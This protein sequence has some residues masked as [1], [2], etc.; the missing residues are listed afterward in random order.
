LGQLRIRNAAGG[1]TLEEVRYFQAL[2]LL[3][4]RQKTAANTIFRRLARNPHSYYGWR[5]AEQLGQTP[6]QRQSEVCSSGEAAISVNVE[7]DLER[8]RRPVV[9]EANPAA[10]ALSELVFLRLWDDAA[11]WMELAGT[12]P[13]TLARAQIAYAAGQY[14][15]AITYADR[16]QTTNATTAALK[17]PAG[18]RPIICEAAAAYEVD[19]LW[20]HAIIWQE[21]K[22]NP[23]ARSGAAARGLMQ[24]I[25]ETAEAIRSA[26][27]MPALRLEQLYEPAINIRLGA[28]LWSSLITKL[29]NPQMALAAYNGG[30][31][32]VERWKNKGTGATDELDMFVADIGFLE[33]KRYVMAVFGAYAAYAGHR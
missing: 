14:N 12:R 27:G 5:A 20:L 8:L 31:T 30:P 10:D 13:D 11:F 19:P 6:A 33:T 29:K 4:T 17:Y 22:Y 21:S 7:A 26:I 25:P 18:Y 3:K 23:N 9:S 16:L 28:S 1:T 2:C 32:N 24:F 15:R